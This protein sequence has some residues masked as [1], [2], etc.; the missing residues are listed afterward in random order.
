MT[1]GQFASFPIDQIIVDRTDRQ[2]SELSGIPELADSIRRIGLIHPITITRSGVLKTGESR[3]A[4]CKQLGWT[5]I[6]VQYLE[7]MNDAELQL[8]ELEENVRRVDLPWQDQCRAVERYHRLRSI[9]PDWNIV[10][11]ADAL[12]FDNSHITQMLGVAAEIIAGNT[13]VLEAPRYSTARGIVQRTEDRRKSSSLDAIA[14]TMGV[15]QKRVAPILNVDFHDWAKT[16]DGPKFNFI[17]CDFPYGVKADNHDQGAAVSF[18]GYEDDP[19]TYWKLLRTLYDGMSNIIAS[20][21][22]LMFW[23]S[24]DFYSETFNVLDEMGWQVNRF[25]LVWYKSDNTGI[26]PDPSRGP[27][28]IYETCFFASRG[29]RKIVRSVSNVVA[30]PVTKTIHMNEK[31]FG[32]LSKFMEMFVDEHSTVLDPT[33][34]SANALRAAENRGASMVLGLE[35]NEEFFNL[36]KGAYFNDLD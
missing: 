34:G 20:S 11:T 24:M 12:G 4:A 5:H 18:G 1:S 16:Y 22:H 33:C 31:P 15:T 19:G 9:E 23:F 8:L 36:A 14:K 17:H 35:R 3:L 32:M 21:A 13:R 26:L 6:S 2:R 27:R 30:H 10:K 29:D 28:R 25:P 7:D